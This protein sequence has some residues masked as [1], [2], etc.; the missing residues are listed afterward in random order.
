MKNPYEVFQHRLIYVFKIPYD[1]HKGLLKIGDTTITTTTKDLPPNCK[2]LNQAA[3]ERI[4]QYTNTANIP[5]NLLHTELAVTDK[6]ISF[7]DYHVHHLLK[8]FKQSI[9][10][11]T[12]RE[13]FKVDLDTAR[14]AIADVKRG[15]KFLTG[16]KSKP[17]SD[18]IEF[19]PEQEDAISRTVKYFQTDNEFLWNAKMRFGKT[20]CALEVVRRM[21]FKKTIIVTHR[22]VVNEGWY[23]DFKKIFGDTNHLYGSKFKG[24]TLED[25]LADGRNFVYFASIQDLRGSQTVND[26]SSLDKNS[27]VF[28]TRWDFVIVD[29]AHEG[30]QTALGDAVI[31]ALVKKKTKFLALSGTPFNLLADYEPASV[32]TWDYVA[33]QQAKATWNENHFGDSNPYAELPKMNIFTYNLGKLFNYIDTEEFS[34]SFREFFST[35][36]AGENFLHAKDVQSFLNLLVKPDD[37]NY[38]F[39]RDDFREMFRHTLWIIPG[40]KEGRALSSLLKRH[41]VFKQFEIVNVAGNGDSDDEPANAL[42]KVRDAIDNH[43]YTITLSCGKLT[44]GVTVPEWTAVLYLAGS[45]S[46]RAATYLQTIFRVQSPCNKGGVSK[47]N[48]YVFDFAPD[49]ALKMVADFVKVSTRAG[50]TKT[51]QRKI[52]GELLNFCPVIAV[53]GS[54]MKTLDANKLLQRIKRAQ[55]ERIVNK[56]FDDTYLYNDTLRDLTNVELELFAD[57]KKIVGVSKLAKKAADIPINE[58][59]LT[60]EQREPNSQS[61]RKPRTPEEKEAAR[62]AQVKRNAISILRGVSIRM[63]LLIYGADVPFDDDF[64]I[65]MFLNPN[66]VDDASWAEFMPA[67][68]TRDKFKAFIKYY[69][70]DIFV[71]AGRIVRD[72][73]KAA[74]DLPPTERIAKIAELFATFKN[75]DK[76][77]VLTPW[78]VVKLHIDSAFD[79]NFFAPDKHILDINAKTGL[80]PLYPLR[81][82]QNLCGAARSSQRK[83]YSP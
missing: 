55:A 54:M 66:I 9:K 40:V 36:D 41:E 76:E 81:R 69:D 11:T 65:E 77:T 23:D 83:F 27:V 57:L 2:E 72:R 32:Y 75:P 50:Q 71:R 44:T 8:N 34:F 29:E 58:Q 39:A 67:G 46:T 51:A 37:N 47:Q 24:D 14:Q 61:T 33:E 13:W 49:R 15:K 62:K 22:P 73:A 1:T 52:L 5:Y 31:K 70:P 25:L 63:P 38:P 7:R 45:Y 18:E 6:N 16:T 53:E 42:E 60:N 20:L 79:D 35:D 17:F 82:L 4:K 43:D 28:K 19:R 48:C 21:N 30:T 74:D 3:H 80:Y 59:G 10:G 64:T 12:G 68:V 26:K 56:G 78:R